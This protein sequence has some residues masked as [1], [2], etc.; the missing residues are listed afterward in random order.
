MTI[1]RNRSKHIHFVEFGW[2]SRFVQEN[3][4][5]QA[6]SPQTP[7]VAPPLSDTGSTA[8]DRRLTATSAIRP[9][10]GRPHRRVAKKSAGNLHFYG[11]PCAPIRRRRPQGCHNGH[12]S[13]PND[14][15]CSKWA[16]AQRTQANRCRLATRAEQVTNG[17]PNTEIPA[18]RAY[19]AQSPSAAL[20]VRWLRSEEAKATALLFE[21]A[22]IRERAPR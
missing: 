11:I 9:D 5:V 3:S 10:R 22:G 13:A 16:H 17:P 2:E 15:R 7:V 20:E 8:C 21:G 14:P 18:P 1:E 6:R 19:A 12:R 4:A